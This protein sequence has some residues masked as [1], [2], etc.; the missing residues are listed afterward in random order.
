M[1]NGFWR[2]QR[3]VLLCALVVIANSSNAEQASPASAAAGP[4]AAASGTVQFPGLPLRR[5]TSETPGSLQAFGWLAVI[6]GAFAT[7]AFVIARKKGLPLNLSR[8]GM[9]NLAKPGQVSSPVVTSRTSL[10]PNVALYTLKWGD[11]E[12]LLGNTV[13]SLTLLA[14]KPIVTPEHPSEASQ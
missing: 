14:R 5:D 4:F 2:A 3:A 7:I 13:Q 8:L 11:E 6:L 1:L 12:L 9:Q 10:G